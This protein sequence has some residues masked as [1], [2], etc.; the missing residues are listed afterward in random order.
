MWP[1]GDPAEG[2]RVPSW[3]LVI[4][5][6][7]SLGHISFLRKS[8]VVLIPNP[9]CS[10]FLLTFVGI[11]S[12]HFNPRRLEPSAGTDNLYV[13]R[14]FIQSSSSDCLLLSSSFWVLPNRTAKSW[15]TAPTVETISRLTF[16]RTTNFASTRAAASNASQVIECVRSV[17]INA[18]RVGTAA[19][20][21]SRDPVSLV[22]R[23]VWDSSAT[24]ASESLVTRTS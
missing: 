9:P 24:P 5:E 10:L 13:D 14:S 12:S 15:Y 16:S 1:R 8:T 3:S 23:S 2:V 11:S 17:E 20:S 19:T 18:T 7:M 6:R 22:A 21:G 4:G